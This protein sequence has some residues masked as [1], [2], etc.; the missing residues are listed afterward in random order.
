[1]KFYSEVLNKIFDTEAELTS[2][3]QAELSKETEIKNLKDQ[4]AAKLSE[5]S[6]NFSE[7]LELAEAIEEKSGKS[8]LTFP[9]LD[10][11]LSKFF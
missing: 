2:A 4:Y 11:I 10:A 7:L 1:M 9:A 8:F 5:V 3:E 6:K